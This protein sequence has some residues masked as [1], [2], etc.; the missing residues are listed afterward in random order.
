MKN[1]GLIIIM[2]ILVFVAGCNSNHESS[3][4]NP[5]PTDDDSADDAD[6]APVICDDHFLPIVFVHGFIEEGDA[7]STQT[8]RFS[9]NGYCQDRIHA[10]D[11]NTLKYDNT[12]KDRLAKFIDAVLD[13]DYAARV[14]LIGHSM[15]GDLSFQYIADP[16]NAAKV[17]HYAHVAS[18]EY[19]KIPNGVPTINLSSYGDKIVGPTTI[20]G[21]ENIV[22]DDKD[23]LQMI[24]SA[25]SF[26][27]MYR[28]FND[29]ETPQ[30]TDI[31][32]EENIE[33]SGRTVAFAI[34]DPAPQME[35]RI[36]EVDPA[37]GERFSQ[38]P[39]GVFI[40]DVDGYWGPF[41]AKHGA[42]YEFVCLDP[43][44][45]WP[46]LHYYREPFLRSN[47]K[48]YFRVFP[49]P[50]SFLGF[51]FRFLP[52]N[53]SRAIFAWL[54][55][56]QSVM[57][58]RDTFYVNGINLSTTEMADP[59]ITTLVVFFFDA[60]FNGKSDQTPAGGIYTLIPFV[61]FFDLLIGTQEKQPISFEFNGRE[62]AI[63]NWKS[64]SE[65]LSIA[66]FE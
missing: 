64:R 17:A 54:N 40:A 12:E 4:E 31:F 22:F 34:N 55:I 48:V 46:P 33:L 23:H 21:A 53:D 52:L 18:F 58:G 30:T 37:T 42:Y 38:V 20:P 14:N 19:D 28:F 15:G 25:E 45:F 11:W 39:N 47:N 43:E 59:S 41:A 62:M 27:A 1:Y 13:K 9:S 29:G 7:F 26:A 61:R 57:V 56:N 6:N 65:G 32:S 35:I 24:T 2:F 50:N 8:M 51:A 49:K 44:T 63:P 16:A 36:Y 10:F 66:V 5:S 3:A 60:N